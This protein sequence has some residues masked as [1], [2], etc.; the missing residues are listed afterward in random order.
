MP[1]CCR[2]GRFAP[3]PQ[4]ASSSRGIRSPCGGFLDE[5]RDEPLEA[6]KPEVPLFGL[7]RAFEQRVHGRILAAASRIRTRVI[8]GAKVSRQ[9]LR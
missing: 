2:K 3:V 1:Y 6:A 4:P 9:C 5:R 8:V 7:K